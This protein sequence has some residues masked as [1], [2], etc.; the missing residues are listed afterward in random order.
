M[1]CFLPHYYCPGTPALHVGKTY[2]GAW[3][4]GQFHGKGKLV[5]ADGGE[6]EGDWK[7]GHRHGQGRYTFPPGRWHG[8]S[9]VDN[10]VTTRGYY[11]GGWR[12]GN[13]HGHGVRV[14]ADVGNS[15]TS[16][17]E[18]QYHNG[19]RQGH[20]TMQVW[21]WSNNT[22]LLFVGEEPFVTH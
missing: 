13:M 12:N 5:Y 16:R 10:K 6:Y 11:A 20:G 1:C 21:Y 22:F 17:Y 7:A 15:G 19:L 14:W 8:S 4:N 18:G 9:K 2:F 3:A